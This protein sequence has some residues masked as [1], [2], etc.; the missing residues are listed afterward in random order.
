MPTIM[1]KEGYYD[2]NRT[3]FTK[4]AGSNLTLVAYHGVIRKLLLILA[5]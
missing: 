5:E 2:H 3:N 4:E 1:K